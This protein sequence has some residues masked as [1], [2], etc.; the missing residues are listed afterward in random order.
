MEFDGQVNFD[1]E[2]EEQ[3]LNQKDSEPTEKSE[4]EASSTE[5]KSE[6]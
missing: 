2:D 5:E 1:M 6:E 4:E 3:S